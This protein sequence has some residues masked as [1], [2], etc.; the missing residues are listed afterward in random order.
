MK[1]FVRIWSRPT[2]ALCTCLLLGGLLS[3]CAS[4]PAE[5]RNNDALQRSIHDTVPSSWRMAAATIEEISPLT[6]SPDLRDYLH[7]TVR[8][9]AEPRDR[10]LALTEA[11]IDAEGIGLVYDGDATHTASEAFR[12]GT[13][14]CLGFSNLLVAS[15]RE[16]GLNARFELVS[17]R[18]SWQKVGESLVGT[19]HV[20]VISTIGARRMTF[21][22]YPLPLESGFTAQAISDAEALAHHLNNL[23]VK[24]MQDGDNA[25]AY[26][27]LYRAIEADPR[28][29]FIWSNLGTLLSRHELISLAEAAYKEALLS[30]PDGLS[31]LS[32]LQRLYLGQGLHAEAQE[33]KDQLQQHREHNPYYHSSQA[34]QAYEQGNYREAVSHY[35]EAIRLKKNTSDFYVGLS[36]SYT[37]LDN[38]KA[39][40]RAARKAQAIDEPKSV[41]YRIRRSSKP[42]TGSHITRN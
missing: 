23:A 42:E 15:A 25:R 32:N 35:K 31:A 1:T 37:K 11:I 10:I 12:S 5:S 36:E 24:S 4:A 29:G 6:V 21:D 7:S 22:F 39:A 8:S 2:S 38:S 40:H 30:S 19:L 20:R 41:S 28:I 13:G 18:L 14:N 33:L 3:G 27:F 16:L 9:N 17:H 34:E 26:G